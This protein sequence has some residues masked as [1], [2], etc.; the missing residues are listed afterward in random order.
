M[1]ASALKIPVILASTSPRRIYLMSQIH[2]PIEVLTPQSDEKPLKG[3]KP[4]PL[5]SRLSTEKAQSVKEVAL[6]RF[7]N[8]L[9]IGAD[10]I[11]V[12]PNQQK[13]LGKPK[14]R[15]EAIK[16]LKMLAGKTHVVLTGYCALMA[17]LKKPD[18]KIV[19]VVQSKVK[20][21]PLTR[22]LIEKYVDSGEPMDKAGA[23]A[24]QGLGMALIERIEGSYAN[25]VGLPIAQVLMDLEKTFKI[26]LFS[27]TK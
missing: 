13:I 12:S 8:C 27:W 7:G 14:D 15:D 5:V 4:N 11:V 16:M 9:I 2:L 23:Y 20:L 21:R 17:T 19:R 6:Q 10:T 3:E 22:T 25:V 26:S 24:A 18:R 1:A